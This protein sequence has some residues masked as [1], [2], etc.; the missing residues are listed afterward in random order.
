M[1]GFYGG[2]NGKS[3]EISW[4]FTTKTGDG[5]SLDKDVSMGWKSSI[6]VGSYVVVSYGDPSSEDFDT[7]HQEDL[8]NDG[9]S[10]NATLWQKIYDENQNKNNGIAYRLITSISGYTPRIQFVTPV[11]KLD[12]DADPQIEYDFS[13]I[14]RPKIKLKLPQSQILSLVQPTKILDA[15]QMPSVVYDEKNINRPTL[16]FSLPQS[17][18][19]KLGTVTV[20]K[21]NEKPKV[22]LN[23]DN[24]NEPALNFTLPVAQLLQQGKTV[25]L[26]ANGEPSFSIDSEDVDN[27]TLTFSLP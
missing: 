20:A 27:P 21:A 19:I 9:K 15:N 6:S 24:I 14:E 1:L 13:D 5:N 16:A 23:I 25:V 3:F 2:P 26:D 10:Y 12:A 22:E 8:K 11:E 17:Q 18:R 7:Y 4:I